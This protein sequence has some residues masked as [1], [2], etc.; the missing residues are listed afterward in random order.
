M[1][2]KSPRDD[3]SRALKSIDRAWKA[4]HSALK[5]GQMTEAAERAAS[6]AVVQQSLSVKADAEIYRDTGKI[7]ALD[8]SDLLWSAEED[9]VTLS[10]DA[11]TF[12]R[13]MDEAADRLESQARLWNEQ[14][15]RLETAAREKDERMRIKQLQEEYYFLCE[16]AQEGERYLDMLPREDAIIAQRADL[17]EVYESLQFA[18]SFPPNRGGLV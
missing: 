6:A 15:D 9:V 5:A 12:A 17:N 3:I 18:V 1:T 14:A 16:T 8:D 7:V 4:V 11:D 2:A 13:V 10:V